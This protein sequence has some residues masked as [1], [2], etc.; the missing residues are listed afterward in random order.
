[1][2]LSPEDQK[3]IRE[4]RQLM[5]A[6]QKKEARE[7][8]ENAA[9]VIDVLQKIYEMEVT[10]LSPA[11]VAKFRDKTRSIYNK[12]A[13]DIGVELVRNTEGVVESAK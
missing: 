3:A 9:I 10:Q 12:W 4:V 11:D 6:V 5:M 7:G 13:E 8:L 1:M 2:N